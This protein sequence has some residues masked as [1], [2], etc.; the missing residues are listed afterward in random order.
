MLTAPA[1]AHGLVAAARVQSAHDAGW[2]SL[3]ATP[4]VVQALR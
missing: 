1:A 2:P 4:L 3:R